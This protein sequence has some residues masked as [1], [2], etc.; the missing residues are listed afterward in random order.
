[1]VIGDS[2][3]FGY[4]CG[5]G[6]IDNIGITDQHTVLK[7]ME[8]RA[9]GFPD[10]GRGFRRCY[11][12]FFV[13]D[14]WA[15]LAVGSEVLTSGPIPS[16]G[17]GGTSWQITTT[18]QTIGDTQVYRR[19]VV[20]IKRRTNG[21]GVRVSFDGGSTWSNT[22]DTNG[23][24]YF[25]V[26][27]GDRGTAVSR[28]LQV[29]WESHVT[30]SGGGGV[31]V[32]GYC[33]YMTEGY[34][35]AYNHV[36]AASGTTAVEWVAN[37]DWDTYWLP[38]VQPRRVIFCVGVN[39]LA[40]A[41]QTLSQLQTNLT[42]LVTRAQAAAPLAEIVLVAEYHPGSGSYN[43]GITGANWPLTFVP[44]VQGV[45]QANGCT[46]IDLFARVG[47]VSLKSGDSGDPYGLTQTGGGGPLGAAGDGVHLGDTAASTSGVDGQ[48][49][50]AET[51]WEKLSYAHPYQ[52]TVAP[53]WT[54][55]LFT[56]SYLDS[57]QFTVSHID[58]QYFAPGTKLRW[59][60]SGVVKYGVVASITP[61]SVGTLITMVATNDYAMAAN[62]DTGSNWYSYGSP[63]DFPNAFSF[64]P[65]FTGLTGGTFLGFWAMRGP[66]VTINLIT[67]ST[68]TGSATSFTLTNLPAEATQAQIM[69]IGFILDNTAFAPAQAEVAASSAVVSFLK[70]GN[71]AGWTA[72][73]QRQ[74]T[75]TF[76]YW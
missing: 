41:G 57:T 60:E 12:P 48:R 66:V 52:P 4:G 26:D 33:L 68:A 11:A 34:T 5:A 73:G 65:T 32:A 30:G 45:A 46:F 38:M 7:T 20:Y 49:M 19:A 61:G 28:T 63:P 69:P 58:A 22:L 50:I 21:D 25:M 39:D 36:I 53:G 54:S 6:G 71:G 75:T 47:D 8:N 56:W 3:P 10:P 2:I 51:Y 76:S 62:P 43:T 16:G 70:N 59:S 72:S 1:M 67:T 42:S 18:G 24:G 15:N 27:S 29:E 44:M 9:A 14:T 64:T 74:I 40:V 23:S 31:E 37:T 17:V 13:S 55:D 35:G